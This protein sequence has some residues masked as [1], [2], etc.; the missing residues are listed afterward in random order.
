MIGKEFLILET[1]RLL[2]QKL[3]GNDFNLL[4]ELY[5][6]EEII[7]FTNW[8]EKN[9]NKYLSRFKDGFHIG[10]RPL[11]FFFIILKES[12]EKIGS[13]GFHN[14]FIEH[15][16][17][18][19][20]YEIFQDKHKLQG[21]MTE[22]IE[23]I[24]K[25]GFDVMNLNRIEASI[26]KENIASQKTIAKFNFQFEGILRSHYLIDGVYSDSILQS[27]IKEKH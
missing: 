1:Q 11:E 18:E 5:S 2:L 22:A 7:K 9:Y 13:C 25:Y 6:K 10:K 16:R 3:I 26:G 14:W 24:V 20:G 21:Y 19:I 17:A 15:N 27:L 12:G 23:I 4:F 8:S